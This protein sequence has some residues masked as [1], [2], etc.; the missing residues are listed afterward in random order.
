[1]MCL[2]Q[3]KDQLESVNA[4]KF[5]I[6]SE[7]VDKIFPLIDDLLKLHSD[8]FLPALVHELHKW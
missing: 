7:D 8:S 5:Y 4:V 1:M 2:M 6:P 3:T